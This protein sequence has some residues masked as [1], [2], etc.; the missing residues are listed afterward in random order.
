MESPLFCHKPQ[1]HAKIFWSQKSHLEF[2]RNPLRLLNVV[3]KYTKDNKE[4]V[5][6]VST[7]CRHITR[8][9]NYK[10][11][12]KIRR[13]PLIQISVNKDI[14]RL[15]LYVFNSSSSI[16]L[17]KDLVG[18]SAKETTTKTSSAKVIFTA[19]KQNAFLSCFGYTVK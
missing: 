11:R 6:I 10:Q 2:W 15:T 3:Y 18:W 17:I 8:A 7:Y 4:V 5:D 9:V 16:L 12:I 1:R 14:I 19:S 13:N